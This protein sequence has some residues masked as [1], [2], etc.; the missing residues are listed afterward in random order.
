VPAIV[1]NGAPFTIAGTLHAAGT[2]T[3]EP[4]TSVS[5]FAR[6]P[7]GGSYR[8]VSSTLTNANGSYV[9][10]NVE[11]A[12]NELYQVRTT[13][14]PARQTAA[15]FEGVQDV[16]TMTSSSS[17]TTVDGHVTFSGVVSPDKAGHVIYLQK[18][19]ADGNWHTVETRFVNN[20]STFQ[21]GWTFGSAGIKEF[22]AQIPG[23]PANVGGV[24][25]PPVTIDVLQPP[26]ASLPTR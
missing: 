22:R 16:V 19:G 10:A 4:N 26:L 2:T 23:G 21:F 11:S 18:M 25:A 7:Q 24:S 5:L 17:I 14:A 20:G 8:E 13:F 1:S 12:T 9:F 15:L 6:R 3:P